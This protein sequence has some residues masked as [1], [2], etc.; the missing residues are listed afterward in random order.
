MSFINRSR[1]AEKKKKK[2][3]KGTPSKDSPSE[4]WL[5]L[6][7]IK[8]MP[9]GFAILKKVGKNKSFEVLEKQMRAE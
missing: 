9:R 2:E 8:R 5:P 7:R 4:G 3:K 1:E 6:L